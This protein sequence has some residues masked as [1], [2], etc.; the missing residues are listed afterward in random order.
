MQPEGA[1]RVENP[2]A[3][4]YALSL[5]PMLFITMVVH[6]MGHL[7]IA[8]LSGVKPS[9]FQIGIGWNL[10]TFYS[11][12]TNIGITAETE[13]MLLETR[14]LRPRDIVSVYLTPGPGEGRYTATGIIP[15][16]REH[17]TPETLEAIRRYSTTHMRLIGR[18][19]E[20]IP[21]HLVL[22]DMAWSLRAA[23]LAAGVTFPDD[24]KREMREAYNNAPWRWQTAITLAGST[25]NVLAAM[26]MLVLAAIIPISQ[27]Q[28]YTWEVVR[29]EP[30]GAAARAGIQ[31]G[32]RIVQV[33]NLIHPNLQELQQE[34]REATERGRVLNIR[35]SRNYRVLDS[36][37]AP[38]PY[39]RAWGRGWNPGKR[40]R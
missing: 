7:A 4:V 35:V 29:T 16:G 8:K 36:E 34:T 22:S 25:T 21:D 28:V 9:R 37:S 20:A 6:E 5:I 14:G 39:T 11:G 31:P 19:L 13:I 26:A 24:P 17:Q 23:P 12:R 38:N 1:V 27:P 2:M 18:V 40:E 15:A 10:I 3:L 30:G 32:D 33:Q